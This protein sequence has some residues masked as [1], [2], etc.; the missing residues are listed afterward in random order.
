VAKVEPLGGAVDR[1]PFDVP[2]VGRCAVIRDLQGA[3]ICPYAVGHDFP[4][5]RGTFLWDELITSD[6]ASAQEFYGELFGW[7]AED[8]GADPAAS[9]VAFRLGDGTRAAGVTASHDPEEP[10]VWI[11]YLATEDVGNTVTKAKALGA[12]VQVE[13]GTPG[14]ARRVV[15]TDPT[16]ALFGVQTT[17]VS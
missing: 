11:P 12:Q 2:G 3:V 14:I 7:T 17:S 13:K 1:A 5:P 16:G 9:H 15:L 6:V 4:P 10:A 8:L